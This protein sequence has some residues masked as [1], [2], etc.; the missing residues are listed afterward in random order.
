[1][2]MIKKVMKRIGN[3]DPMIWGYMAMGYYNPVKK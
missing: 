1:M 3:A 2:K